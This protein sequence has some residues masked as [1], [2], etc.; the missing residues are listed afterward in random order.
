MPLNMMGQ[1]LTTGEEESLRYRAFIRAGVLG[2]PAAIGY[3]S[4]VVQLI[5]AYVG[6]GQQ[7]QNR[8]ACPNPPALAIISNRRRHL[9]HLP[10]QRAS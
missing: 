3:F 4:V 8:L 7:P 2:Q 5:L 9:T 1:I 6:L 10:F